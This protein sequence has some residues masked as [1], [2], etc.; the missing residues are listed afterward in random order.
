MIVRFFKTGQSCGEAPVNYLLRLRDHAG[1]LRPEQPEILEGTP[2]L[3]IA[4]INGIS[5]QHK[6]SSGCLA[7]RPGGNP[8]ISSNGQK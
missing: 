5:R 8:P 6:Y 3:T 4:L 7:F 1:E 2:R